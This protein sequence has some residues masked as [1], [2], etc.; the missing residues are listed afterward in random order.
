MKRF[1]FYV[2][3]DGDVHVVENVKDYILTECHIEL[4]NKIDEFMQQ[5]FRNAWRQC[6]KIAR[7]ESNFKDHRDQ[8]FKAVSRFVRCNF[9]VRD[10][11]NLD[12]DG[13]NFAF[14]EV[15]CPLRGMCKNEC[16]IC[17][18]EF[19]AL[20]SRA[21]RDVKL[22]LDGYDPKQIAK[23]TGRKLTSVNHSL[24]KSREKL[25]VDNNN[26]LI[27]LLRGIHLERK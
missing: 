2:S 4:I 19:T 25:G 6:N 24:A 16:V 15:P 14:E 26:K 23:M 27:R 12:F 18:P 7:Q 11:F 22:I 8:K 21:I 13:S 5:M 20:G 17:K 10:N 3:P 1:E 9:G